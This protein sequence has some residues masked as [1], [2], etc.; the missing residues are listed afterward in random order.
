LS[1]K[2][3]VLVLDI[4]NSQMIISKFPTYNL[5]DI[6]HIDP[7]YIEHDWYLTCAAWL[8]VDAENGTYSRSYSVSTLDNPKAYKK[9]FRDDLVVVKKMHEVIQQA[10][11]IVGHNSNAFDLKKINQKII[12]YKLP[13]I[14]Y[15]PT[16]DTL[17]ANR[18]YGKASSNSLAHLCRHYGIAQKMELP[19]GVMHA[20]D[21]GCAKSMKK[22]VAYNKQD[23][24]ST[25]QLYLRLLPYIKNHPDIR[26]ILNLV[27]TPKEG[28]ST[29]QCGTCGSHNVIKNGTRVTKIGTFQR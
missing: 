1:K 5:W 18:K 20:A 29:P 27:S 13:T 21:M 16:V 9:N 6:N 2:A 14:D 28:L 25:A 19:K 15:P 11:I 22:L 17:L 23:I 7:K 12:D 8:W 10:D 4:E 3:K 24:V 26:R